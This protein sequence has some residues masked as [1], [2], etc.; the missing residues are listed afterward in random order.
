MPFSKIFA[1]VILLSSLALSNPGLAS[2][3]GD[4]PIFQQE[5]KVKG[6]AKDGNGEM[7]YY[8]V[9]EFK[10]SETGGDLVVDYFSPDN[11]VLATKKVEFNCRPTAPDFELVDMTTNEVEGVKVESEQITSYQGKQSSVLSIPESQLVIDAGFD[12]AVKMN[13]DELMAG[14]KIPFNY[15]FARDN[16]FFKLRLEKVDGSKVEFPQSE[17]DVAIFKIDA[18][19][20][21]FRLFSSPLFLGYTTDSKSLKYYSGPSNL[22][23]MRDQKSVLITYTPFTNSGSDG[24]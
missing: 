8:E 7:L 3:C 17:E 14:K 24:S 11:Q 12:N 9:L 5:Y 18:N 13:W 21:I 1:L 16:K 23:M 15:L 10:T 2:V 20:L 22:P 6:T 4:Q 19:N